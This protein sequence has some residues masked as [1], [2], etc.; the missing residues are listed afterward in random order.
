M[1]LNRPQ[2]RL[3]ACAI[4]AAA[5]SACANGV[6]FFSDGTGADGSG[7]GAAVVSGSVCSEQIAPL[8]Q[9]EVD[10][11]LRAGFV[12]AIVNSD[13]IQCEVA[14]GYADIETR[15][16][17]KT[18]ARFRIA[19]MTKPVVTVAA[20]QLVER[21][22]IGPNDPV[23]QFIPSFANP[24]VA[25]DGDK[26]G[27]GNYRTRPAARSVTIHD[28]M[29]H[30]A[31]VGYVF[32][33]QSDLDREYR[34]VSGLGEAGVLSDVVD[35]LGALPLYEDPGTNWRY[36]YSTDILGRV[37]EV[38]SGQDLETFLTENIFVPLGMSDTAFFLDEADFE[39]LASVSVFNEDGE[40]ERL[41]SED[42]GVNVNERPIGIMS[43]GSALLSTTQDYGRFMAM[44]LNEGTFDGAR[45]LSP[46]TV[47]LMMRDHTPLDQRPDDWKRLGMTF[48]LGGL[49]ILE[50]G[51]T[52]GV[53]SEGEWGWSGYWDTWFIINPQDDVGVVLMAQTQPNGFRKPSRMRN[54]VKAVA[55]SSAN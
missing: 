32:S 31:G 55:Y 42:L 37:I 12:A 52:G 51:Y 21:G 2:F 30:R 45:I 53:A 35:A 7:D 39:R 3:T 33:S 49:V 48:G 27:D 46:S 11:G 24:V 34:E 54:L 17:L 41:A 8:L 19:S 20:M 36:S 47:R 4:G 44:M 14:A 29:T 38:A 16:P 1:R 28:L 18:D 23:E 15:A 25:L 10:D 9:A 43:G 13:G 50:P 40:L 6:A 26:D 5:L 22:V